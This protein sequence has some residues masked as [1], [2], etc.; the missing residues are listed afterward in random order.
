MLELG[1][2]DP[3]RSASLAMNGIVG[4]WWLR[5]KAF[6]QWYL[7]GEWQ[8]FLIDTNDE[9]F[10]IDCSLHLN[11]KA[12]SCTG[13][14]HYKAKRNAQVINRGV[15]RLLWEECRTV[16]VNEWRPRFT[17]EFIE[18]TITGDIDLEPVSYAF[19]FH[20]KN[21]WFRDLMRVETRN[22]RGRELQGD[23]ARA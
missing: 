15:N 13:Y 1:D 11:R 17:R 23:F 12:N 10:V 18:Y 3:L 22:L 8:G 21:R 14:L 6:L 16:L 4:A 5:R 19:H 20:I 2:L 9:T 7:E